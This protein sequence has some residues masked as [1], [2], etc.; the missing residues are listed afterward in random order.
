MNRRYK[1]IMLCGNS[2]FMKEFLIEQKKLTR[3][4]NIVIGTASHDRTYEN[5]SISEEILLD[6]LTKR[7]IEIADE[8]LVVN[9]HDEINGNTEN[10]IR[11]AINCGKPIR[12]MEK[13]YERNKQTLLCPL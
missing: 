8:I 10:N 2:E 13:H 5:L 11:Y 6:D 12:Y 7:Q 9:K 4:G 1:I 3:A